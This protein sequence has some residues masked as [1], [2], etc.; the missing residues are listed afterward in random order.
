MIRFLGKLPQG[1]IYIALS[2]GADSMAVLSFL[3][4]GNRQIECL[5]FNHGTKHGQDAEYFVKG[6]CSTHNIG[7]HIGQITKD[8]EKGQSDEEYWRVQ[9]YDFFSKFTDAP[10]VMAHHLNDCVETWIFTTLHGSPQLIPYMN[11]NVIRPFLITPK[12]EF[13]RWNER[14][15]VPFIQDDSNFDNV[16]MRN[17]IRNVLVP[18][19]LH[20]NPGLETVIKKKLLSQAVSS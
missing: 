2:G 10:I 12:S 17:Y 5:Y 3:N 14:H 1:K 18:N 20:V 6:Y 7:L 11:G 13:L 15:N 16:H 4:N 19:S 8:K 9:R